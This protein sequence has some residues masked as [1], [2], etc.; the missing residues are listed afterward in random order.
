MLNLAPN[1]VLK[2]KSMVK[3]LGEVKILLY[4]PIHGYTR[5][6]EDAQARG[7]FNPAAGRSGACLADN[8]LEFTVFMILILNLEC[9]AGLDRSCARAYSRTIAAARVVY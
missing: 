9:P 6:R 3:S 5:V 8:I 1:L 2:V 7:R 4:Q